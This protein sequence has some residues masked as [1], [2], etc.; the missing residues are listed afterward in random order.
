MIINPAIDTWVWS[1]TSSNNSDNDQFS[2]FGACMPSDVGLMGKKKQNKKTLNSGSLVNT[3]LL[4]HRSDG[5]L[6]SKVR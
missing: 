3:M 2:P 6:D 1:D 4:K 5:I